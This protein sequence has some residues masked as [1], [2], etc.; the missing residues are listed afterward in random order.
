MLFAR[1]LDA[2]LI[3]P[4]AKGKLSNHLV[5][6]LSRTAVWVTPDKPNPLSGSEH[7]AHWNP[8]VA[9][10]CAVTHSLV[11]ALHRQ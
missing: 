10:V 5:G 11:Q 8:Q 9:T 7:M 4:V 1:A 6:A 3:V 2:V